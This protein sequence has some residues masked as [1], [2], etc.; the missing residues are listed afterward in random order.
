MSVF[1]CFLFCRKWFDFCKHS[2]VSAC[3]N[4]IFQGSPFNLDQSGLWVR[5]EDCS[6]VWPLLV[7]RSSDPARKTLLQSLDCPPQW[8]RE[9]REAVWSA[10]TGHR[11]YFCLTEMEKLLARK[12]WD[13]NT[14]V[15]RCCLLVLSLGANYRVLLCRDCLFSWETHL[16]VW[17]FVHRKVSHS[18]QASMGINYCITQFSRYWLPRAKTFI[19]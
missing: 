17:R 18:W 12:L 9:S 3:F 16:A 13:A 8:S 10:D 5:V 6:C 1:T 15:Q 2:P 11:N 14:N 4:K 7:R 19:S